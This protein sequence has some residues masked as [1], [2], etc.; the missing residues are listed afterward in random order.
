MRRAGSAAFPALLTLS[1]LTA[2]AGVLSAEAVP[3]GTPSD[4]STTATQ[5][6]TRAPDPVGDW[7]SDAALACSAAMQGRKAEA[8]AAAQSLLQHLPLEKDLA[9]GDSGWNRSPQY[10]VLV[11][12]GLW[13]ELLALRAPPA[14]APGETLGWLYG[15][16]VALAARG[17]TDGARESLA[18]I[19]Q[20]RGEVG[21][22]VMAGSNRLRDVIEV[23]EPIVAARIA[24][25]LGHSDDAVAQLE[26][27]VAAEDR[28]HHNEP[29]DWFFPARHLLGAQ[30]LLAGRASQA[31]Q[32]YREDLERNP[33]N[34]WS[35]FGLAAALRADGR[36]AEAAHVTDQFHAS[37]QQ[38]DVR[39]TASAFWFAGPDTTTCECQR[40]ASRDR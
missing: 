39:L 11:R 29:A 12:F 33:A 26:K 21:D 20:L 37:W 13:D 7:H 30:L 15:R 31:A 9:L 2:Q 25:T 8:L 23:A 3:S 19:R 5:P 27:A 14:A 24:A 34:G 6:V 32:V 22:E 17:E 38:A 18:Q 1:V 4:R 40:T 35:L 28:L 36:L 10:A 16:G